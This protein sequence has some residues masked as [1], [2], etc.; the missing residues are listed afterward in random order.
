MRHLVQLLSS[1]ILNGYLKGFLSGVIFRG[2]SKKICIPVLNCYS[3]P[4][5]VFSCPLGIIQT[6]LSSGSGDAGSKES[7]KDRF[8]S[9][10]S[11]IP[12]Y[13]LGILT[14][15]ASLFGRATCGWVCPFGYLQDLI[16]KIPVRKIKAPAFLRYGKY[17]ALI[18]LVILLPIYMT[19]SY[20]MGEPAFCKYFCPAGTIEG[21]FILPL[22]SANKSLRDQ[23][24]K[25]FLWKSSIVVVFLFSMAFFRRPFCSWACPIGAFLGLFNRISFFRLKINKETCISCNACSKACPSALDVL[26][27]I[28][29]AECIKCLECRKVCPKNSICLYPF[30]SKEIPAKDSKNLLRD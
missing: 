3:C 13:T 25:L 12:V 29:S 18:F 27:E 10:L 9:L 26:K 23:L 19:D 1:I 4:G 28:D 21:G 8:F 15:S 17:L 16:N 5:A 22:Y 14:L 2:W 11:G 20:G 6:I 24:G 30:D 7:M